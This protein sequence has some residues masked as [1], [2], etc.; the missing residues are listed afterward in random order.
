LW[1]IGR[2]EKSLCDNLK[3][4][5]PKGEGFQPSLKGTLIIGGSYDHDFGSV[6]MLGLGGIFVETL[7]DI[8]FRLAPVCR[9]EAYDN[10]RRAKRC[11]S[12]KRR[13]RQKVF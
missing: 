8:V 2:D 3:L 4:A 5:S 6:V 1:F 7:K 11:R 12:F 9:E 10:D 13:S